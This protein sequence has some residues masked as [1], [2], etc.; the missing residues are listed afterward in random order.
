[1]QKRIVYLSPQLISMA[2]GKHQKLVQ[3]LYTRITLPNQYLSSWVRFVSL[4]NTNICIKRT[5]EW[6]TWFASPL[7]LYIKK[8]CRD[9]TRTSVHMH[10]PLLTA[11]IDNKMEQVWTPLPNITADEPVH[12]DQCLQFQYKAVDHVIWVG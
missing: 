2:I 3:N 4:K 5:K 6:T 10:F 8:I 11:K 7:S 9:G 1:M 12:Q